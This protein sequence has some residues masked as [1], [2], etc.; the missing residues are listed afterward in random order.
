MVVK[1]EGASRLECR[2][3]CTVVVA[4]PLHSLSGVSHPKESS[5]PRI[6]ISTNNRIQNGKVRKLVEQKQVSRVIRSITWSL[7]I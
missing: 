2:K 4:R 3:V 6:T 5:V 1:P 7:H